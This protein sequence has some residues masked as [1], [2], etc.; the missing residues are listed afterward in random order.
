[1]HIHEAVELFIVNRGGNIYLYL[2]VH[3][4]YIMYINAVNCVEVLFQSIIKF[5]VM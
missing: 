5:F 2:H 3:N 4:V 1:M